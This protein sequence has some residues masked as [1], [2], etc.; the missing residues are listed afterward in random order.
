MNNRDLVSRAKRLSGLGALCVGILVTTMTPARAM[1]QDQGPMPEA[2]QKASAVFVGEVVDVTNRRRWA[3]VD[4]VSVWKGKVDERV[5]V[6]GGPKDPPGPIFL[7]SSIERTYRDG[8]TYLFVVYRGGSPRGTGSI[9]RDSQCTPTTRYRP[10]LERF[11]PTI[12][13][14]SEPTPKSGAHDSGAW[15]WAIASVIAAGGIFL[16]MRLRLVTSRR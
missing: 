15:L 12:S 6:R 10:E 5:E 16:L 4:V 9:F 8:Q 13:V 3:Q 1:C 14:D 2:I 7:A 11:N